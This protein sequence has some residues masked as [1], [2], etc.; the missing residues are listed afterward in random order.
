[1]YTALQVSGESF[2]GYEIKDGVMDRLSRINVF[3]GRNNSGKSRF[4][5]EIFKR[6]KLRFDT[7]FQSLGLLQSILK[8][9]VLMDVDA[10]RM[11]ASY[12]LYLSSVQSVATNLT[13]FRF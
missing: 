3:I 4:L 8:R 13:V 10:F 1:M 7:S 5:R 9:I 6:N 2:E 12:R 11:D